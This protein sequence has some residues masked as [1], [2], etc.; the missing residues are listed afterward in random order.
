VEYVL[1]MN[2]LSLRGVARRAGT[3]FPGFRDSVLW[4]AGIGETEV[5][6]LGFGGRMQTRL[7]GG[8][9]GVRRVDGRVGQLFCRVGPRS[10]RGGCGH[11]VPDRRLRLQ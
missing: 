7:D 2:D 9:V 10:D 4:V 11:R 1:A 3:D 5:G 6:L 8:C